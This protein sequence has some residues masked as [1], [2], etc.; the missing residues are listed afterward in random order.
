MAVSP[1]SNTL[2]GAVDKLQGKLVPSVQ[3]YGGRLIESRGA[4]IGHMI[5]QAKV[6]LLSRIRQADEF[7]PQA[8][9]L[10]QQIAAQAFDSLR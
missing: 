2:K 9:L 7:L 8:G 4:I 6:R 10:L 1:G 5:A 3:R